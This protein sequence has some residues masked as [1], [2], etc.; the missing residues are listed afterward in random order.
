MFP[1]HI[2]ILFHNASPLCSPSG[3]QTSTALPFIEQQE[4]FAELCTALH[5]RFRFI[6][7]DHQKTG[8]G[9]YIRGVCTRVI[10]TR[11][12]DW[13]RD[14]W[15]DTLGPENMHRDD[16]SMDIFDKLQTS[17]NAHN[18]TASSNVD[19]IKSVALLR[20][21]CGCYAVLSSSGL[22]CSTSSGCVGEEDDIAGVVAR[23][24]GLMIDNLAET[25]VQDLLERVK[26]LIAEE[27]GYTGVDYSEAVIGGGL[28]GIGEH[29]EET[30]PRSG[31]NRKSPDRYEKYRSVDT[32]LS[33]SVP[34]FLKT[35]SNFVKEDRVEIENVLSQEFVSVVELYP[36]AENLRGGL[37]PRK[38]LQKGR[39]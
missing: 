20:I 3:S 8:R 15:E 21:C 36:A 22:W 14:E 12:V 18:Q 6:L 34:G 29:R 39:R 31:T 2:S 38:V 33:R 11:C 26:R 17:F 27:N 35:F 24:R 19:Y 28:S 16:A 30:Y 32:F 4:Y 13:L 37:F 23:L 5:N 7:T 1:N 9:K 10:Q 25:F